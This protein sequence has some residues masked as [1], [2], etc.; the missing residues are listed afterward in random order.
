MD[1]HRDDRL[2]DLQL[3]LTTDREHAVL[4][5][6]K[7]NR[8]QLALE[9]AREALQ[10]ATYR[11]RP[12]LEAKVA[13]LEAMLKQLVL[14]LEEMKVSL[15]AEEVRVR[16]QTLDILAEPYPAENRAR[17]VQ[18]MLEREKAL[19]SLIN[20]GQPASIQALERRMVELMADIHDA[21]QSGNGTLADE[22]V[23]QL[24]HVLEE[25]DKEREKWQ[26]VQ[27]EE[28]REVERPFNEELKRLES[29]SE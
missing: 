14:R 2:K 9:N 25:L 16:K 22:L 6:T 19:H 5:I 13:E 28:A 1:S 12:L 29:G 3:Q 17:A 21:R 18:L 8:V 15:Q 23:P 20:R 27:Q 24:D 7:K 4:I 11:D 26:P 10:A